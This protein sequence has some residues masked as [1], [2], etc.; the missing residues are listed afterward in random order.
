[1]KM[2]EE[3]KNLS[4]K[5]YIKTLITFNRGGDWK[6]LVA[7]ER[8]SEGKRYDCGNYCF[9]NL[10][11]L[12]SDFPPFYSVDTAAGIIIGNG[13]VG[14]YIIVDFVAGRDVREIYNNVILLWLLSLF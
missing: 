4:Y 1:M 7:P 14:H 9:L 13:N 5:D 2:S 3:N 11:G 10:F 8:D 12:S 6:R